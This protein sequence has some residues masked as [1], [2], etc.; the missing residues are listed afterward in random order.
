MGL[1]ALFCTEKFKHN[2]L[3]LLID[4]E[5][6]LAF[7]SAAGPLL[8]IYFQINSLAIYLPIIIMG[9]IVG[10]EIPLL[11]Y[12]SE[13]KLFYGILALDYF[14]ILAGSVLFATVLLPYFGL[15]NLAIICAII[16]L[17]VPF[18]IYTNLFK[19]N[20]GLVRL[21]ILALLVIACI[22][23]LITNSQWEAVVKEK[24]VQ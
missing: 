5:I 17:A 2:S 7:I 4:L 13:K 16:N 15:F 3:A 20:I 11:T 19:K 12:I 8:I 14:G 1:G 9:F 6:I 22:Y 23:L 24:Y 18:I 21:S 10:F